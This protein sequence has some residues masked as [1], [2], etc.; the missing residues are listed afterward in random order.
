MIQ[1]IKNEWRNLIRNRTA[2][3][4]LGILVVLSGFTVGQT[5]RL[6]KE[7]LEHR[8][9][10][11]GLMRDRFTAQGEVN[12]HSAAHYGHFVYKPLTFL[13]ILDE[14]VNPYSGVSLYLEGHRQ[15]EALFSPSQQSSSSVRFGLLRLNLILQMLLPLFILFVCHNAISREREEQT[16]NL[17][18]SQGIT[19]RDLAWGKI[20]AYSIVW[21]AL[22]AVILAVVWLITPA[23]GAGVT[24]GRIASLFLIY[25]IYYYVITA[26]AV[27]VSARSKS[28]GNALLTLL[29]IWV[30]TTVILPKATANVGDNAHPLISRLQLEERINEDNKNGLDGHDPRNERTVRFRDSLMTHYGVDTVT[31]LPVNLD[32]LTMQADEEYHN[33][34]YDKHF[35]GIRQT[36]R[37]QNSVTAWSSWI[38]PFAALRNLSMSLAGTDVYHHFDFMKQAEDYRRVI[39]KKMNDEQAYGGSKTGDWGWTVKADFWEKINDFRYVPRSLGQ[40]LRNN[41]PETAA[42]L[43]W[44]LLVSL[45]IHFSVNKI[46]TV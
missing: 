32:G 25:S 33:V 1:I 14:G 21:W 5:A 10:A 15:N 17:S 6:F 11:S 26:V 30:L 24:P 16:L 36:V 27:Y 46:K 34:V 41:V 38:N 18:L 28:S 19:L 29:A 39:I 45:L 12:P 31:K 35:D 3:W 22:L 37:K 40:A 4:L 9:E 44:L 13:S 43:F 7:T 42:L 20:L 23:A 2:L 8:N